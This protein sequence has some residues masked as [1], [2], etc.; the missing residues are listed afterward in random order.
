L[1]QKEI[2]VSE[3]ILSMKKYPTKKLMWN[4]LSRPLLRKKNINFSE[5]KSYQKNNWKPRYFRELSVT[6]E[7]LV[8]SCHVMKTPFKAEIW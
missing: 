2:E 4:I 1:E 6:S 7:N 3:T 8:V 5:K